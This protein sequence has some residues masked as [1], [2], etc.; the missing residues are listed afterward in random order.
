MS[1]N[2]GLTGAFPDSWGAGLQAL[3]YLDVSNTGVQG[4]PAAS[5]IICELGSF[6]C[7]L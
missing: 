5:V 4:T 1:E 7:L 3:T 6:F 2:T